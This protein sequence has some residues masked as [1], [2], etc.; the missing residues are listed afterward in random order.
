[1]K[2]TVIVNSG[3]QTAPCS[4]YHTLIDGASQ[5]VVSHYIAHSTNLYFLLGDLLTHP[6]LPLF[7]TSTL[8]QFGDGCF[9]RN[10]LNVY[11]SG[12]S[13]QLVF[14]DVEDAGFMD[15]R[16]VAVARVLGRKLFLAK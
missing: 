4:V 13:L 15:R 6:K 7:C 3:D 2:L 5:S 12:V 8:L 14:R 16:G 1:M 10:Y 11:H 9:H